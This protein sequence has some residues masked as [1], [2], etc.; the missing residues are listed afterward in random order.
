MIVIDTPLICPENIKKLQRMVQTQTNKVILL[1]GTPTKDTNTEDLEKLFKAANLSLIYDGG[2]TSMGWYSSRGLIY[3]F[4]RET[5][6][7]REITPVPGSI[8]A[9]SHTKF[10]VKRRTDLEYELSL[11]PYKSN[12]CIINFV[13][14]KENGDTSQCDIYYESPPRLSRFIYDFFV[15]QAF[16]SVKYIGGKG[17]F[18]RIMR[19]YQIY[20]Y[21]TDIKEILG[22]GNNEKE[23][24]FGK[25]K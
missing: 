11:E 1:A 9:I 16:A 23:G 14:R 2:L 25:D 17:N 3:L 10:R 21:N 15:G 18:V 7:N 12:D 4:L 8:A 19:F 22:I 20:D 6:K 13:K 5:L 24:D